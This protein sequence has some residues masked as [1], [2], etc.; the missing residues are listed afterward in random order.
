M[1]TGSVRH[2][3]L[4]SFPPCLVPLPGSCTWGHLRN[5]LLARATL[6]QNL[7]PMKVNQD[8][9]L[10]PSGSQPR[11][12]AESPAERNKTESL[13]LDLVPKVRPGHICFTATGYGNNTGQGGNPFFQMNPHCL[14]IRKQSRPKQVRGEWGSRS[15]GALLFQGTS[16]K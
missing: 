14:L 4:A 10:Q 3:M 9:P 2:P 6:T 1:G 11:L 12:M 13:Y 7:L 15:R 8:P 5:K 16:K